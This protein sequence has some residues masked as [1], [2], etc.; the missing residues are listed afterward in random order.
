MRALTFPGF[1]RQYV[2]NLSL[3]ESK[4][5]YKL[6][7]EA[8]STNP[9]LREPL[10]LYAL[11]SDKSHVLSAAAKSL[12]MSGEYEA[13][14][15]RYDRESMEAAL[16][17]DDPALD[18]EYRKVYKSY[19]SVGDRK[20]HEDHTKALMRGKIIRLQNEAGVSNYRICKDLSFNQGNLHAYLKH[21][22]CSKVS[23]DTARKTVD[24]LESLNTGAKRGARQSGRV[25]GE[26]D[27]T[28]GELETSLHKSI[29]RVA[30]KQ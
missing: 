15:S 12:P 23:L 11:F 14:L 10:F 3:S 22:D 4:S 17:S 20:K 26:Q 25:A 9:R 1:L 16:I 24:Y 8:A 7:K 19:L 6:A 29:E 30:R 18:A 21:G 13:L 2:H 5:L 28:V 27:Y